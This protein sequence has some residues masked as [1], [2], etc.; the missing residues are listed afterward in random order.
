MNILKFKNYGNS[1]EVPFVIY[2]DFE[3]I[4]V[5]VDD[6]ENKSTRKLNKHVPWGFACLTTS[7][8]EQYNKEEVVVYS[9]P[10]CMSRFFSHL[11]NKRLRINKILSKIIPM[12]ELT[13][14]Q[15][16]EHKNAK[17]CFNCDA[18]FFY[19]HEAEV[20]TR[21]AHHDHISGKYIG[22][23]CVR[24][25]LALKYK[26]STRAK[27]NRPAEFEIPVVFHNLKGYDS[28]LILEHFPELNEKERVS[29]IA[30]NMEQFLTFTYRGL[31][32]IDSCQFMKTSLAVLAENLR[33]SG[34]EK[35]VH[36]KQHFREHFD[37][38][39]RKGVYC[40]SYMSSF[41]KFNET[42]LPPIH[43]FYNDLSET[44]ITETEYQHAKDVWAA[45]EMTSLK[46]YHDT[47]LAT[48]VLILADVMTEFSRVCIRDYGLDP[49]HYVSLPGFS[50][51]S[52]MRMVKAEIS[53]LT[54]PEMHLFIESSIRGGVATISQR[55][56]VANNPYLPAEHYD[57]SKE[58]SYVIYTDA[59]NMYGLALS[60]PLPIS[61]FKFLSED[62][63]EQLDILSIPQDGDTG[64]FLEVDLN[65]PKCPH[66]EH[67]SLPLAPENIDITRDMLSDTTIEMG[68]K[69]NSKFLPQRKLCPNLMDKK[70]YVLHYTNLQFYINHGMVLRKIHRVLSFT[71]SPW[72]EPYIRF[73]TEKR[74]NATDTFSKDLYKLLSNSASIFLT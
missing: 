61:N 9:G 48:D 66:R 45:F 22:P 64:Y 46:Q 33:K 17:K 8:C 56:A 60:R 21:T 25:N 62:E 23:A 38:V 55:H 51:D 40:Y 39:T 37:L 71:Q 47:Y 54:D 31:K 19:D 49:K 43:C 59:N 58:H 65:Y 10:D 20:F 73:N 12:E 30:T 26:Q 68:E 2:A 50:W 5:E 36:T 52:M 35:F 29:C 44:H 16:R 42:E 24:C 3:A 34:V 69:F 67:N 32:F 1:L 4:L 13:P 63:I 6:D 72:I 28:K 7:S 27:K 57:P 53:L 14:E 41:E 74:K 15:L 70:K 18:E 11:N